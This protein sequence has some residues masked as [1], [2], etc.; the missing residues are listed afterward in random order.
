MKVQIKNIRLFVNPDFL[1]ATVRAQ[2]RFYPLSGMIL[3]KDK[4]RWI[5]TG[6]VARVKT[7]AADFTEQDTKWDVRLSPSGHENQIEEGDYELKVD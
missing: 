2:D 6:V 1:M 4:L 7:S 5:I 3:E